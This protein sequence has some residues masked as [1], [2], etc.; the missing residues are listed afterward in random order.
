MPVGRGCDD[1]AETH[2]LVEALFAPAHPHEPA[3]TADEA[4][5]LVRLVTPA[6][7]ARRKSRPVPQ[8]QRTERSTGQRK[9]IKPGGATMVD[10]TR[11]ED[12]AGRRTGHPRHPQA[13]D[14]RAAHRRDGP[15]RERRVTDQSGKE[16]RRHVRGRVRDALTR[17]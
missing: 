14:G 6:P 10:R 17:W 13:E 8:R 9:A 7:V 3:R 2:G 5:G 11:S 1:C 4:F 15:E 12:P 16:C